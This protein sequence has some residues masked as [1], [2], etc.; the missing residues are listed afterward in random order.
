MKLHH[1]TIEKL[2]KIFE[3]Y[4]GWAD[5]RRLRAELGN[6]DLSTYQQQ[7]TGAEVIVLTEELQKHLIK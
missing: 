1:T 6:V 7:R 3:N 5:Q 4:G 2:V